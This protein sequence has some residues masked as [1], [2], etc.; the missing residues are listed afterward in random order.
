MERKGWEKQIVWNFNNM[1][2]KCHMQIIEG[3][4]KDYGKYLKERERQ[5]N[6]RA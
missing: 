2:R 6:G 1:H 5:H 4:V 3:A